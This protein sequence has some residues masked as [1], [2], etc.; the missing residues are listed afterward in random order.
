MFDVRAATAADRPEVIAMI[1]EMMPGV[2]AE[3]RW[4]W[5]Y[6]TSPGGPALTWIATEDG[7]VA[8]CTSFFPFRLSLDGEV[9]R[10]A[11]GGDGYVRP[12]FRRRGLGGLLHEASRTAM[13]G[14]GIGCMYGAPGAMNLTPLKHGG[15]REV[16]QVARWVRPLRAA[17]LGVRM[18]W[19]GGVP[20]GGP[21]VGAA[22]LEPMAPRDPRVD[23]VWQEARRELRLAAVRD[24]AFYTWR[25]L[26]APSRRQPAYVI[27]SRGQPIGACALESL[28]GGTMLWLVD[29]ITV[30]GAWHA[31]LR[32][33]VRHALHHT[34]A[35]S[36]DIKLFAPD[37]RRRNMWRSGFS[38]RNSKPFL[39]MVPRAGDRRFLDPDRWYYNGGDSDL[40]SLA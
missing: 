21:A 39:C 13:P 8:G 35:H 25:F 15:S 16:G 17:G 37:G 5:L 14:L 28:A 29:L 32:A 31:G 2:D 23:Q 20:L 26:D 6:E 22:S 40:D 12:A 24:A 3:A 19:L 9:V 4:R 10:A 38:E 33:I 1:G 34:R 36:I 7:R 18:P 11:L 30:P 27:V